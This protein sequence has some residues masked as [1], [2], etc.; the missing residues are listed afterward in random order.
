MGLHTGIALTMSVGNFSYVMISSYIILYEPEWAEGV[1]RAV[2]GVVGQRS[3]VLYDGETAVYQR[4]SAP[5]A[6]V[7]TSAG[8]SS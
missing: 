1:V 7:S 2:G 4:H 5:A 6:A 3:W 8:T